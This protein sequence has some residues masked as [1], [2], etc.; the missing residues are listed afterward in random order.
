MSGQNKNFPWSNGFLLLVV[1]AG[2][3][4]RL[5]IAT[6]GHN[7]DLE[8]YQ[9]VSGIVDQGGNVYASTD[10]YNYGPVWFNILHGLHLLSGHNETVFRYLISGFLSLVDVGIFLVLWRQYGKAAAAYF[11]LN[12]ISIIISGYHSQFDNLAILLGLWSV[13]LM[14]DEFD[15]P[16]G[17]RK[18]WGL[19]VLGLSLTTK[20]VLFAFP[21]WLAVKQRGLLQKLGVILIP[22]SIFV[23]S[24]VPYWPAG[25]QGIVQNVFHYKSAHHDYYYFYRLFVP[26]FVQ[27]LLDSQTLWFFLLALFAFFCK[28]KNAL[29]SLLFYT[30]VLVATSP[31]TTN[32]YLAIPVPFVA[33]HVNP[34][35][36]MYT[37]TGLL[38]LLLDYDGLHLTGSIFGKLT[39]SSEV[40]I[41][42]LCFGLVWAT[43][44]E[45]LIVILRRCISEARRQ[46]GF[47]K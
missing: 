25:G 43:W 36:V 19:L 15:Q 32:Q 23:L 13:L 37:A 38:H 16:I 22:V 8:S 46:F 27:M 28:Q 29:E 9:V 7:Y 41:F 3:A 21:F 31:A 20:H 12:P 44:R 4:A 14:K 45:S 34:F 35:T 18:L 1:I 6:R 17:R 40:P 2:F 33:T 47:E 10:R 5:L 11:F 42:M 30:A 24:F 26:P 39:A